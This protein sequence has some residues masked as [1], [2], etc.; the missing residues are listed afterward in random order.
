MKQ[1]KYIST[2]VATHRIDYIGFMD[3]NS[4]YDLTESPLRERERKRSS[5]G[6]EKGRKRSTFSHYFSLKMKA[7]GRGKYAFE[8]TARSGSTALLILFIRYFITGWW[9]EVQIKFIALL[10]IFKIFIL[11]IR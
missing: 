11:K 7:Y 9:L 8:V 1:S 6:R 4:V 5:R 10:P 3:K 2:H